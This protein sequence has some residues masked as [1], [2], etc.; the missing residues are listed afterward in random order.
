MAS[1]HARRSDPFT[2]HAAAASVLD[3][4]ATQRYILEAFGNGNGFTDD[5]LIKYYGSTYGLVHPASDSSIRS[6]RSELVDMGKVMDTGSTRPTPFGRA[7]TVW[8]LSGRLF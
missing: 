2:S 1:A 6:R 7:S 3:L 5:E 4:T 8:H